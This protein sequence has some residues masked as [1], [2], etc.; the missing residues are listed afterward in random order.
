MIRQY[1]LTSCIVQTAHGIQN[2]E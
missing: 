2:R 1:S